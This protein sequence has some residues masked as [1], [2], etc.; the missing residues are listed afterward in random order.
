MT[1]STVLRSGRKVRASL[2][3]GRPAVRTYSP[4]DGSAWLRTGWS[5]VFFTVG[6]SAVVGVAAGLG[7]KTAV[8]ALLGMAVFVIVLARPVIGAYTLVAVVPPVS[9]L[10]A[11]LPIPQ[12]RPAEALIGMVGVL[13]LLIARPGQTPR[14]R[15]FDWWALG[16]SVANAGLGAFDLLSSGSSIT[17]GDADKLL[18]PLQFFILYRAVLTTLTTERQRKVALRL[19]LFASVPVSLLAVLQEV[20]IPGI[21]GLLS[22]A[23]D[24][25]TFGTTLGVSRATGPF[26]IWHDLGSYLFVIVILGVSLLVNQ[27]WQVMKPRTLAGIVVLAGIAL[28]TTV[29]FTP[30]A[31]TAAGVLVLAVTARPRKQWMTRI[32]GFV[33][34]I[35]IA[36]APVLATR[37][38]QQFAGQIA[39]KQIPYLP[40]NFNFRITVWTT[41]FIPVLVKHPVTGYGPNLPPNLGFSYTE[42][43]YVTLLLRGG[44]PLLLLYAGLMLTLALRA[45]DLRDDPD[46][47]RRAVARTLFVLIVLV[48]FMQVTTNY[49]VNAGFPFIFWVLAGLLTAGTGSRARRRQTTLP[50]PVPVNDWRRPFRPLTVLLSSQAHQGL[51]HK[52]WAGRE[53]PPDAVVPD[54]VLPDAVVPDDAGQ[55]GH[56]RGI[57][58]VLRGFAVLAAATV[59]IRLIGFVVITLFARKVGPQSFG[60]YAFALALASFVVGVPTNFGIG[61]LGIRKIARDHTDASKVV[62]EALAVQTI[63][64]AVTV[65][66]LVAFVPLFS[67]DHE[68]V[69]L[70]PFVALYYVAYSMTVDWALQGLQRLRAV[71]IAR[72]AGQVLFGIVTPLILIRGP[73]GAVRYAAVFAAGAVITAI[74]A[75]VMVRR[76]AGPIRVSWAIAPL[77]DLAKRAAPLGFSAIMLQIY[78]SM[79][80][81]LL[82]LLTNKAEV[83]QYAAAAKLPAVLSGFVT[84]WVSAVYP[85]AS[86]LFS[87][88]PDKLRL[89]LGTFTSLGIGAALPL[90]AGSAILGTAMMTALFGPAYSSAGP[91]FAILMAASAIAMV[92]ANYTSLAMA[93]GQERTFALSVTVASIINVLLNLLLIPAYGPIGAAIATVVAELV[94]LLICARR[95]AGVI[96]TPLLAGRRIAGSVAATAVMSAALIAMPSSTS[97]WLRI[98]AGGAVFLVA[99]AVSGTVRREDL[100][101]MRH[102]I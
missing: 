66:L 9:G 96:G 90:T 51:I 10:R 6:A 41:E 13:L 43:V 68:L 23:T 20:H 63:I 42:S 93:A 95:V 84:I 48:V 100:A 15:A 70:M 14:W 37:Y 60:T 87:H 45:R 31:G 47:G 59:L 49:F 56:L 85:H 39:V 61:M 69:M 76:L 28:I 52:V 50:R 44:L 73:A 25:Q 91:P 64:A 94:V 98:A 71:A 19:L 29:S 5:R 86:K 82:G 32:A 22:S 62:G 11:G 80:Q 53:L 2:S 57:G 102:G 101:L 81:V 99:A 3:T 34:L 65:A 7:T 16:Y 36:F 77:W 1:A 26:A 4:A 12:V 27:A 97:V 17:I 79:D 75:F 40:Q 54:A 72:L 24:S 21:A 30:I 35:G 46:A 83:G 18:G 55:R 89:Q 58:T 88:S 92:T 38:Q 8:A 78:W 67:M 33:V 74:V